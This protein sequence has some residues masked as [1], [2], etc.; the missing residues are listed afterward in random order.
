V[1]EHHVVAAILRRADEVLLC[2]QRR[3]GAGTR[4]CGTSPGGHV[5]PGERAKD[6]L[7][8]EVAEELGAVLQSL[9]AGP[10]CAGSIRTRAWT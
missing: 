1:P 6:A 2:H 7:S 4:T 10:S 5:P 8:R 3:G 9:D